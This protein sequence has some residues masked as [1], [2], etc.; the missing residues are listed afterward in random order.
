MAASSVSFS[1]IYLIHPCRWLN[2]ED[3]LIN[4]KSWTAKED[5]NLLYFVQEKGINNWFDIAVSLGTNRT[6]FQCLARYQRSLNASILKRE[7]TKDEDAKLRS[8]VETLGEG[9]W[10]AVA[11]ALG[12]RAG[13]QCSNR[14]VFLSVYFQNFWSPL[15]LT[16]ESHFMLVCIHHSVY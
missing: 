15:L 6:P 10:Q 13:T 14:F 9:N 12:G 3:P 5:K 1:L 16:Q 7:W 8:A 2:W 4:R 11:S